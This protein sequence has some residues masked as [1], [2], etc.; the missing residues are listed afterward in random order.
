MACYS[1]CKNYVSC[2]PECVGNYF[3]PTSNYN[4]EDADTLAG[5]GTSN[6]LNIYDQQTTGNALHYSVDNSRFWCQS[7][8]SCT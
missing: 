3:I 5:A 2:M 7:F 6:F 8:L 4:V 1:E